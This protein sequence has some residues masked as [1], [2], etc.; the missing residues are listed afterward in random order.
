MCYNKT[1]IKIIFNFINHSNKYFDENEPWKLAKEDSN[2]CEDILYNCCNII[3][4]INNLLKPFFVETTKKVENYLNNSI[5]EWNY[6]RLESVTLSK[7][8]NP[9]FVR[10]DKEII[11]IE[12]ENLNK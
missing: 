2:K 9:L 5:N 3:F 1:T 4:N 12:K 10:Y 7:E 11:V 8:I 6:K